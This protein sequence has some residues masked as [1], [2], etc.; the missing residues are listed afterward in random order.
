MAQRQGGFTVIPRGQTPN[1]TWNFVPKPD[2]TRYD[3]GVAQLFVERDN[4]LQGAVPAAF[5]TR[6]T[7]VLPSPQIAVEGRLGP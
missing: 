7:V 5:A 6:G 2:L 3:N 4:S 1:C